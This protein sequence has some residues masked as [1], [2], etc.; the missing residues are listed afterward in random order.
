VREN[1]DPRKHLNSGLEWISN[2]RTTA[3]SYDGSPAQAPLT[4][5]LWQAVDSLEETVMRK[6]AGQKHVEESNQSNDPTRVATG[7]NDE[8]HPRG[9]ADSN[10]KSWTQWAAENA[11]RAKD[12][13]VS[14][15][16]YVTETARSKLPHTA[17]PPID[18]ESTK[19]KE[20]KSTGQALVDSGAGL[21]KTVTK[22][23]EDYQNTETPKSTKD[24]LDRREKKSAG[25]ALVESGKGLKNTITK[26]LGYPAEN[27]NAE[28]PNSMKDN[29]DR[30][31]RKS[32]GQA[33]VESGTGLRNTITKKLGYPENTDNSEDKKPASVQDLID[34]YST[35]IK[36][37]EAGQQSVTK[38]V[39]DIGL[40]LKDGIATQLGYGP[41]PDTPAATR[42]AEV[43][44]QT[45]HKAE[46]LQEQARHMAEIWRQSAVTAFTPGDGDRELASKIA[47][48]FT[49]GRSTEPDNQERTKAGPQ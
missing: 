13:A 18:P 44:A 34:R 35:T 24:N 9:P 27:H 32:A 36:T 38:A 29:V 41:Q 28:I 14:T 40:G 4:T 17:Q 45:W 3:K 7:S 23:S 48:K 5:R 26:K 47:N 39:I 8:S 25:Q 49:F 37:P 33:L 12:S 15:V 31:E 22:K 30:R 2:Q 19:D 11:F 21:K 16:N 6:P 20:K 42:A 43:Q 1:V 46:E 10:D